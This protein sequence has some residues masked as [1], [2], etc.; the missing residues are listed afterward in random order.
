MTG[1]VGTPPVLPFGSWPTPITSALVVASAVGLSEVWIDG[2]EVIWSEVRPAD[3][4]RVQLVR[5]S[6]DGTTT[7]LLADGRS[8]RN[9]VHEYGGAAWWVREGIV[10]FAAWD[11][12][13]LYRLDTATAATVALTPEPALPRGDRYADGD[14]SPDGRWIACVREHHPPDGHGSA[15]VRNEIVRL[16]AREPA[17]PEVLVSGPD[18]TISPR[19]SRCGKR[20]CWIEWDHPNMPWDGARLVVRNLAGGHE[21]LIAG[22]DQESVSEPCWQAD[23]SL[24]FISDRTGWWNLYRWAPGDAT[25]SPLV[26]IAAE[27]GVPQ[28]SLGGSRYA[29]LGD[30]R[31]V[32]ARSRDGIDGL[33]VRSTEGTVCELDVPF[34]GVEMVRGF[35]ESSIALIAGTPT[36]EMSVL[37]IDFGDGAAVRTVQALRPARDLAELGADRAYVSAP[38][39]LQ[40][41][42]EEGRDAYAL[43]Y[44]PVN[45][46]CAG[47]Q[48]ELPPLLLLGH[49]GPTGS[50]QPLLQLAVQYWTS[51]GVA[52]VDVNYGGSAGYGRRYRELL[53]GRWGEV[54]VADCIAAAR[55]LAEQGRCDPERLCIRGGSAGGYTTLVALAREDTPFAAGADRYGVADLEALA[56][57]THKFESHYLDSLV[58]PYPQEREEYRRRSPI[59]HVDAFSRPL[60][61]F[62]GLEDQVVPPVQSEMIVDALRAKGVPV[63]YIGFEGEQHGFRRAENIRRSL[64]AELSFYA[65]VL[66]FEPPPGEGIEPVAVDNLPSRV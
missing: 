63:A 61:V 19:W 38:E 23:G 34:S 45:P 60:I 6:A 20:L 66:G 37:R 11:D 53:R 2:E 25:P 46:D 50:A 62:Q 55:W 17:T 13:R 65:Q 24:T 59:H 51:R 56:R 35:G 10:W 26:E 30:G 27:I 28:W 44:P 4:G 33:A 8:A 39:P 15:S 14:V 43:F 54:D 64:D 40:F 36:E 31:I 52:V 29:M 22:G 21:Q 48:D 1:N 32:F 42:S 18:F 57:D 16:D 7:E 47:P 49:G 12:Q 9:A 5:R 41:P 3:A 58:G